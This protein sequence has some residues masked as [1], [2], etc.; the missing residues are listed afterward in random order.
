MKPASSLISSG[1]GPPGLSQPGEERAPPTHGVDH[2]V[3]I[4]LPAVGRDDAVDVRH[5]RRWP[6]HR[7]AA[8]PPS[9]PAARRAPACGRQRRR[10][11]AS[12]VG[13]RPVTKRNRSS[14]GRGEWSVSVGGRT[15]SGS[16]QGQPAAASASTRPGSSAS[17]TT[18]T[19]GKRLCGWR[20]CGTPGR[21]QPSQAAG[22]S[23]RARRGVALEHRHVVTVAGQHHP[24]RQPDHAPTAHHD[25]CHLSNLRLH[26]TPA[27]GR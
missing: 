19:R 4:E 2:Q 26:E 12:T 11:T 25:P 9:R 22:A 5:A 6:R 7:C 1:D 17:S 8:P 14:S 18:R 15:A 13:R 20:N 10:S 16:S 3:G 27:P 24:G 21:G 23:I